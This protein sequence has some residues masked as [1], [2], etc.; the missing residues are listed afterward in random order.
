M[1]NETYPRAKPYNR[2]Q[3]FSG[4]GYKFGYYLGSYAALCEHNLKPD[5]IL[6]TCGG[7]LAALLV[8]IAPE[9]MSLKSLL[10]SEALYQVGKASQHRQNFENNTAKQKP[11]FFYQGLKRLGLSKQATKLS[12][13][14]QHETYAEL[15]AELTHFAMFEIADETT[16]LDKLI[17]Q[18]NQSGSASSPE[19]AI[20]ASRLLA[21]KNKADPEFLSSQ[22]KLQQ[23]LFIPSKLNSALDSLAKHQ[24][25][26]LQCPT[27]KFAPN[28]IAKD[29]HLVKDW[30]IKQAVRASMADMYYLQPTFIEGLGWSLGGVIDLTP[31]ELANKFGQTVFAETKNGYDKVLAAPAIKRIFGFDPNQRLN[32]VLSY[33]DDTKQSAIHWLPFADNGK[34]LAGQHVQKRFNL[35]GRRIDLIY[36]DYNEFVLQMHAQW[37]YGYERTLEY[38]KASN[39]I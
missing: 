15:L 2:V 7:S 18:K 33:T 37:R 35:T 6:A 28:R 20:I 38:L 11:S 29:I 25:I 22:A 27:H 14:H 13:I 23:V 26:K 34:A 9:P 39:L 21:D 3:L 1:N 10:E 30:D 36:A 32:E 24:S 19:V 16:W 5:L 12:K 17:S 31:I 4:G 8:D